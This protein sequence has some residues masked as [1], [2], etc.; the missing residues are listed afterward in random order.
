MYA[1]KVL[2]HRDS[3]MPR[4]G[5]RVS[6]IHDFRKYSAEVEL[7]VTRRL[8]ATITTIKTLCALT[9]MSKRRTHKR[10]IFAVLRRV[11]YFRNWC[12][13]T[14]MGVSP[15]RWTAKGCSR[16]EDGSIRYEA[17]SPVSSPAASR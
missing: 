17:S 14:H 10:G 8:T 2:K 9:E 7:S 6:A 16:P 12:S 13:S 15:T 4:S 11:A 5:Q 3:A 1:P